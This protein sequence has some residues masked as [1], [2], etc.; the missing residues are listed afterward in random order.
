MY[1][2]IYIFTYKYTY[3]YRC[4]HIFSRAFIDIRQRGGKTRRSRKRRQ[5]IHARH[6]DAF[7][8]SPTLM[9]GII[10]VLLPTT[11][12]THYT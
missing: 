9:S 11:P 5:Q 2:Y 1:I 3:V 7:T 6:A 10:I 8:H 4:R 12:Q